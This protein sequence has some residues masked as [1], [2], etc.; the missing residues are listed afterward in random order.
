MGPLSGVKVVEFVGIGPAPM[1][2]MLL[3][4]MGATVLL[5]DRPSEVDLG[6]KLPAQVDFTKRN[7][8]VIGMD[9]KR[10]EATASAL[11]LDT[12][13]AINIRQP[14]FFP[15]R[16]ISA[17]TAT[18]MDGSRCSRFWYRGLAMQPSTSS[19]VACTVAATSG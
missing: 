17:C 18:R 6:V 11:R 15:R 14:V 13:P 12:S 7:R 1:A 4:D 3:A 2:A 8:A 19:F 5:I 16:A 9:L 10:P